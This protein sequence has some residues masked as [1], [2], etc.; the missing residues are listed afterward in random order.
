MICV[1]LLFYSVFATAKRFNKGFRE[2]FG[3][4]ERVRPQVEL[5]LLA[6]SMGLIG[7][8]ISLIEYL[9]SENNIDGVGTGE[10]GT[11]GQLIPLL[12]GG[13]GCAMSIWKVLVHRLF[14][15]KR[16][17]FLFGYHL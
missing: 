6:L 13:L 8:S 11:V 1:C 10:I 9:I 5:V 17:W 4:R 7:V 15:R 3:R 12:A 16:C 14:L 2:G